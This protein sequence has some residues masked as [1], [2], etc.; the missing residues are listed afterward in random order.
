MFGNWFFH[1]ICAFDLVFVFQKTALVTNWNK[2]F[3]CLLC[4]KKAFNLLSNLHL[5]LWKGNGCMM[6]LL[7][8]MQHMTLDL[9]FTHWSPKCLSSQASF[10]L[11]LTYL[12]LVSKFCF[13]KS[14]KVNFS[15]WTFLF[16]VYLE[17]IECGGGRARVKCIFFLLR[18]ALK[19]SLL[20]PS[21]VTLS[22]VVSLL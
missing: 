20:L 7:I 3:S 16:I 11:H 19:P 10:S 12:S 4:K 6:L 18:R 21:R 15:L 22:R 17:L 5:F 8:Q 9:W 2:W 13:N 14:G 1:T